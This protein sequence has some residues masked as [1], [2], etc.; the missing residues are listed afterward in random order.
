[1]TWAFFP[2]TLS[3]RIKLQGVTAQA[4]PSLKNDN[5]VGIS[6]GIQD[7]EGSRGRP[8]KTGL[9]MTATALLLH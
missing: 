3:V 2:Q 9:G 1:M 6:D 8:W 5:T 4:A 7:A